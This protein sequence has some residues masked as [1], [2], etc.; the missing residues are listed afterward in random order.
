MK[1]IKS[2][3][4]EDKESNKSSK[5][6]RQSL[7]GSDNKLRFLLKKRDLRKLPEKRLSVRGSFVRS[8]KKW[9]DR[10]EE[11]IGRQRSKRGLSTLKYPRKKSTN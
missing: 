10:G 4:R 11:E 3:G 5:I 1:R 9:R 8:K 2:I 7:E 6:E